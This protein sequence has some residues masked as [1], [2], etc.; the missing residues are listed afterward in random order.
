MAL[1]LT[2]VWYSYGRIATIYCVFTFNLSA[3]SFMVCDNRPI[4]VR[5]FYYSLFYQRFY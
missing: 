2:I 5:P 1:R 3:L 4:N